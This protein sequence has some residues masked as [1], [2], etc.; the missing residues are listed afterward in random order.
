MILIINF[1]FLQFY[2]I[3]LTNPHLLVIYVSIF[4]ALILTFY[5]PLLQLHYCINIWSQLLSKYTIFHH[6]FIQNKIN[7]NYLHL[8]TIIKNL[9]SQ[10]FISFLLIHDFIILL[11]L[12]RS[13][14]VFDHFH[15]YINHFNCDQCM[16]CIEI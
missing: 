12:L 10:L 2:W 4:I 5:L 3:A 15:I 13:Q 6:C 16:C 1:D 8:F 9:L 11:L 7:F 14:V